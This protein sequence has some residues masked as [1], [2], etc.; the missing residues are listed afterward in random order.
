MKTLNDWLKEYGP[1]KV[2]LIGYYG[3]VFIP[4]FTDVD[5]NTH[6]QMKDGSYNMYQGSECGWSKYEEPKPK[7]KRWLWACSNGSMT[8]G[9][10]TEKEIGTY[11]A[12]YTIKLLWSETEFDAE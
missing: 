10:Y 12:D 5:G 6:G 7:I 3:I 2:T 11:V 8:S 1:D 9:F 4:F